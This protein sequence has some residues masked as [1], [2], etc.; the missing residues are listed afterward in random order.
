MLSGL[1]YVSLTRG[2]AYAPWTDHPTVKSLTYIEQF[3]PLWVYA[4]AWFLV[5]G[6]VAAAVYNDR[7]R[8]VA[9]SVFMALSCLW[10]LSYLGS[11]IWLDQTRAWVTASY[12]IGLGLIALGVGY[13]HPK[14]IIIRGP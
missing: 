2:L 6:V 5:T 4:I 8:P 7:W 12:Y 1:A 10:A 9:V 13:R 3:A 14:A 11:W